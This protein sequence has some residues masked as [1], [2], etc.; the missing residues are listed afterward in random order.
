MAYKKFNI[1][2]GVSVSAKVI[3]LAIII[4]LIAL[5]IIISVASRA[6]FTVNFDTGDGTVV[7]EQHLRYGQKVAEPQ[8][9]TREGYIFDG[10]YK[11]KS[12]TMKYDFEHEKLRDDITLY[13]GW[14]RA[15]AS[16]NAKAEK[17]SVKK[18]LK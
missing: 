8:E 6:G 2:E 12:R 13:A 3:S 7:A 18:D 10:W 16:A 17:E 14:Q 5:I 11:D 9:P 1:Y 15:D 4:G